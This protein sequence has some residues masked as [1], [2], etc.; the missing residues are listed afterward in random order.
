MR[1]LLWNVYSV[2]GF[3]GGRGRGFR[4]DPVPLCPRSRPVNAISRLGGDSTPAEHGYAV[5][6]LRGDQ[7]KLSP[8][9]SAYNTVRYWVVSVL[10]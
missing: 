9:S 7:R 2:L 10:S 4:P 6:L 8:A 1:G 5:L 3:F